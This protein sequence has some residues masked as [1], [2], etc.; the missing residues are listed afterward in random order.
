MAVDPPLPLSRRAVLG[1]GTLIVSAP[2]DRLQ[3]GTTAAAARFPMAR[4]VNVMDYG[5]AAD[6]V[7]DDTTAFN[8]ATQAQAAWSSALQY[9]IEVPAGTYRIDGTIFVR[10]GQAVIGS[11]YPTII[12][13][14][15]A[16][17]RT[18]VLGSGSSDV[19]PVV[20][21]GGAPVSLTA[22][23][24]L[25]G[26]GTAAVVFTD[27]AGF[28][29]TDMFIGAP[30]I[31]I[32]IAGADGIVSR[33]I[34]DQG[35]NGIVLHNCQNL[36]ISSIELYLVNYG[37]TIASDCADIG[38]SD[39]IFCYC[40][41]SAILFAESATD[42]ASVKFNNCSF[43]Y[44]IVTTNFSSIIQNRATRIE[45][46][47]ANCSFRNWTGFA[48]DHGHGTDV[49]LTFSDCVFDRR[50]T[51]K[52]YNQSTKAQ[53]ISTSENGTYRFND[54]QLRHLDGGLARIGAKSSRLAFAGGSVVGGYSSRFDF[55]PGADGSISVQDVDGFARV[56]LA[57]GMASATLPWW[58]ASTFWRI[59]L[60]GVCARKSGPATAFAIELVVA[61]TR[62]PQGTAS[63][64]SVPVWSA[65]DPV[66]GTPTLHLCFG[67][68]PDGPAHSIARSG[69]MCL[70]VNDQSMAVVEMTATAGTIG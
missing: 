18:F 59:T 54:C 58:G 41:Y 31:G 25:G 50:H 40:G 61:V 36:M 23:R 65:S 8:R 24:T 6:G 55:A 32:E 34:I 70:S 53:L 14:R 66:V 22:M 27:A 10:K 28:S 7:T 69:T 62:D 60:R 17:G 19:G 20:D 39:S 12:D 42:I 11:G 35:L 64:S 52:L 16:A 44:N 33:I 5:A 2:R 4:R 46:H 3:A 26:S 43:V 29:I 47:F 57:N 13:A 56:R 63:L 38:L 15:A 67:G 48:I 45:A 49:D 37:M 30:G 51:R 1:A 68:H 21:P 9:A